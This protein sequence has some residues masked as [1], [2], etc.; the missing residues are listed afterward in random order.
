MIP[1]LKVV[2]MCP[3][4]ALHTPPTRDQMPETGKGVA[5]IQRSI[6][7]SQLNHTRGS[8]DSPSRHGNS[9]DPSTKSDDVE[10]KSPGA[11]ARTSG[12]ALD[13]LQSFIG[14]VDGDVE[15]DVGDVERNVGGDNNVDHDVD[16]GS[17][18][19]CVRSDLL[20]FPELQLL[21]LCNNLVRFW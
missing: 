13:K 19:D 7:T 12:V 4:K 11:S 20:P 15:G 18:D 10:A 16:S 3:T 9:T 5:S 21:S 2:N 6:Y 1:Q 14:D 8:Q 17:E